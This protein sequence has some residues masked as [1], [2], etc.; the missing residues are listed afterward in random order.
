MYVQF[1]CLETIIFRNERSGRITL[2][3]G[4]VEGYQ[5]P[6]EFTGNYVQVQQISLSGAT[7]RAKFHRPL[8]DPY[9]MYSV[10]IDGCVIWSV[11]DLLEKLIW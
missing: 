11:R 3:N 5:A 6:V 8:T 4:Y 9:Q 2:T 10:S 1:D 7:M